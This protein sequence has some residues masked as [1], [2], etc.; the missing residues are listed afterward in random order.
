M[1]LQGLRYMK[2]ILINFLKQNGGA[3]SL[4][5]KYVFFGG[6]ITTGRNLHLEQK[7]RKIL[8]IYIKIKWAS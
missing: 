5:K 6:S 8:K 7:T 3:E 2:K 4:V 1:F